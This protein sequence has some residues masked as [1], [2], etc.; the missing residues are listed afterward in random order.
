L[1]HQIAV[2]HYLPYRVRRGQT[3]EWRLKKMPPLDTPKP[4]ASIRRSRKGKPPYE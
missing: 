4:T 3:W 2:G 1:W